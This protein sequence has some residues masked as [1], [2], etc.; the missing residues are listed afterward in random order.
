MKWRSPPTQLGYSFGLLF[1]LLCSSSATQAQL[2]VQSPRPLPDSKLSSWNRDYGMGS[3]ARSDF[4]LNSQSLLQSKPRDAGDGTTAFVGSGYRTA[5]KVCRPEADPRAKASRV[6]IIPAMWQSFQFLSIQ[7]GVDLAM[8]PIERGKLVNAI[9]Q[10]Q[11]WSRYWKTLQNFRYNH[12][13]DDDSIKTTYIGHP[14]MGA[15]TEFIWI[16][17]NPRY[18]EIEFANTKSY[19]KSRL[20]ATIP[21]TIYSFEWLLG[22]L[23]ESAMGNQGIDYY[24]YKAA[25]KRTNSTGYADFITPVGGLLWAAGEDWLDLHAGKKMRRRR[26]NPGMLLLSSLVTPVKSGASILRYKPPWDRD[27]EHHSSIEPQD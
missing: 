7:L 23:S 16:Q 6:K 21:T 17:N 14:M 22:P 11:F 26:T 25:H 18:S 2:A 5:D 27:S 8:D 3:F 24:Y 15:E 20:W 4:S 13:S 19:W 1:A 9:D 12:Y 10:G